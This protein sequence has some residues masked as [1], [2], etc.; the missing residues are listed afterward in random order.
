M[1]L[2]I[3]LFIL[4]NSCSFGNNSEDKLNNQT[5]VV[6]QNG[7]LSID[8]SKIVNQ[9][10]KAVS[11]AGNSLF[12]S[13]EYYKGHTFYNKDVVKWLKND[14]NSTIIRIPVAADP[15]VPDSYLFNSEMNEKYLFTVVDAAIDQGLYVIIDWHSHHAEDH[16]TEVIEFFKKVAKKYG[17][18]PNVIYEIY[19][20]P[21]KVSWDDTIKPFAEKVIKEIRAIDP[22]NIIVVGTPRWSQDVDEAANNPITDFKNIA[23]TLHFYAGSHKEWLINKAQTALDKNIALIVTEWGSVKADGN[24]EVDYESVARW[25]EFMK[26]NNIIHCNWSIH[27][28]DEGASSLKPGASIKGQWKDEDLTA[29]GKLAKSYIKKWEH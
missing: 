27:D 8:G 23:Y 14:W 11:F 6:D 12:W 26:T 15:K 10:G 28:K 13:N 3:L 22:D 19:N 18:L 24:G 4:L 7:F 29:S 1:R 16:E 25:M 5:T 9:N 21:L 17:H 2:F 20:E